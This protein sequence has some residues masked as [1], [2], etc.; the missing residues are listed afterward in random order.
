MTY[1]QA[2][3]HYTNIKNLFNLEEGDPEVI[4]QNYGWYEK[5]DCACV[6]SLGDRDLVCGVHN[7]GSPEEPD[8]QTHMEIY[9]TD[10]VTPILLYNEEVIGA[11]VGI[12]IYAT[13]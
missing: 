8:F 4:M 9:S 13:L 6:R 1:E 2:I 12:E 10:G 5:P 3:L 11:A 7:D